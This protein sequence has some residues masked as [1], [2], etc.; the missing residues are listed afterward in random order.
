MAKRDYYEVLGLAKGASGDEIRKA[1][2][3]LAR[4]LH[5]D[6]NKASDATAKFNEVQEA[7]DVLSDDQKRKSYDQ[8]GHAGA[9]PGFG[10]AG[11]PG[12]GRPHYS[13]SNVGGG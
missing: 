12:A 3:N 6:V 4:K 7:Y 1:Y 5:P 8:F 2:R 13:W 9:G 10:A 11:G